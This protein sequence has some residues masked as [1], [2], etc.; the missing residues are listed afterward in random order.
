MIAVGFLGAESS[1]CIRRLVD[2]GKMRYTD[3]KPVSVFAGTGRQL[4][5]QKVT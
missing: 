2:C 1:Q 4:Q 5:D 3:G